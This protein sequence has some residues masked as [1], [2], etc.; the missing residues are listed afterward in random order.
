M[1]VATLNRTKRKQNLRT[2]SE[3][4]R[5]SR[6]ILSREI[7]KHIDYKLVDPIEYDKSDI[8]YTKVEYV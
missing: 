5:H 1:T 4:G 3:N 7:K 2:L 8:K 6:E